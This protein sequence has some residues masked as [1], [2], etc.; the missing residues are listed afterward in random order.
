MAGADTLDICSE[1]DVINNLLWRIENG[2][3]SRM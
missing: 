2:G 1:R 3:S